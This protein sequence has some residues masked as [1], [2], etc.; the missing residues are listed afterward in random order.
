M[1]F[2]T[3]VRRGDLDVPDVLLD[4]PLIVTGR[5][6]EQRLSIRVPSAETPRITGHPPVPQ[7][8]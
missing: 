7:T 3:H 6:Y 8:R 1:G 2:R 4:D 5:F